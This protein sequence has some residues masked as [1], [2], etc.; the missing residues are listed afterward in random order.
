MPLFNYSPAEDASQAF[1]QI[2]SAIGNGQYRGM[3]LGEQRARDQANF[4]I[5]QMTQQRMLEELKMRMQEAQQT[6]QYRSNEQQLGQSRLDEDKH[7]HN[8]MMNEFAI[9]YHQTKMKNDLEGKGKFKPLPGTDMLYNDVTGET[10]KIDGGATIGG[11]GAGGASGPNNGLL[12]V[13][14]A[15]VMNSYAPILGEA[16]ANPGMLNPTNKMYSP[17]FN[18]QYSSAT[19]LQQQLTGKVLGG[20]GQPQLGQA[21]GGVPPQGQPGSTGTPMPQGPM[22]GTNTPPPPMQRFRFDPNTGQLVPL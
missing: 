1:G 8:A 6:Q 21:P 12:K 9:K 3:E 16:A 13:N 18:S 20:L 11:R 7:R 4:Y 10:K 17:G 22:G 15:S 19:N 5:Q 14:P 2:P